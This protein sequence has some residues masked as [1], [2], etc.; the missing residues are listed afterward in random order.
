MPRESGRPV[1]EVDAE[2][3]RDLTQAR[4]KVQKAQSA[5][6]VAWEERDDAISRAYMGGVNKNRIATLVGCTVKTVD[7]SLVR[8]GAVDPA[9]P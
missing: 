1:Q 2:T 3:V 4:K 8:S 5:M 6:E 7:T 9:Y